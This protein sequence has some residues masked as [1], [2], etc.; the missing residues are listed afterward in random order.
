MASFEIAVLGT[1]KAEGGFQNYKTDSANYVKGILIGTCNGISAKAYF[2]YYGKI[3]T[4]ADMKAITH[5]KAKLIYKA[6]YWDR[7]KGDLIQNQ[8]VAQLMFQFIIGSGAGQLS[9][10][11][12]IANKVAKKILFASNDRDFTDVQAKQ[13][14]ELNQSEYHAAMKEWRRK[15]F[16]IVVNNSIAE[17]EKKIGR[18][19]T[20]AEQMKETKK[21]FLKGWNNRLDKHIFIQ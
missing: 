4:V 9:D 13:I 20:E 18:K 7:F 14:N 3:P 17:Y 21:M 1:F 15:Y 5:E 2:T 12:D 6:L 16:V 11:K 10:L 19:S 8:T